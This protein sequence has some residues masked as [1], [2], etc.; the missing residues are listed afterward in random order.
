MPSAFLTNYDGITLIK[1]IFLIPGLNPN[2]Y[3]YYPVLYVG[4]TLIFELFFYFILSI[5]ILIN[6]TN[7]L[8]IASLVLLSL[9][10]IFRYDTFLGHTNILFLEFLI[11]IAVG[12]CYYMYKEV[13]YPFRHY[14]SFISMI[15]IVI[16]NNI[17]GLNMIVA[18]LILTLFL[19]QN[20]GFVKFGKVSIFLSHLGDISYS[21]YLCHI[22]IIGWFYQIFKS[23]NPGISEFWILSFLSLITYLVSRIS[24]HKIENA[25]YIKL[26]KLKID[27]KFTPS[28]HS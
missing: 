22:I 20:S 1:S 26:I 25:K 17:G 28:T 2:G 27:Q 10:T 13:L 21:T 18:G 3:G 16:T 6:R 15:L 19:L 5:S 12:Y 23:R 4:W 11:G 14:I 9:G 8:V 24:Y 7:A